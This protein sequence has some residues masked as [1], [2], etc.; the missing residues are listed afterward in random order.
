MY[1]LGLCLEG[2]KNQTRLDF[3]AL[4]M[5]QFYK[6]LSQL[7]SPMAP[8][9]VLNLYWEFCRMTRIW[10]WMKRLKWSGYART[11]KK[12]KEVKAR[13][14]AIFCLACLQ[15]GINIPENWREDNAWH[16]MYINIILPSLISFWRWVYKHIF[17]T[18]GNFKADH[19]QQKNEVD[20]IWLSEGSGMI[21]RR[22]EY[23]S[24]LAT[25]IERLTVSARLGIWHLAS[26]IWHSI[27]FFQ[28][29]VPCENTFRAIQMP[30][31]HQNF[32]T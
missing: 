15:P 23:F 12:V 18:D 32:A 26:G 20:D 4:S 6:L 9:K 31:K 13:E 17:V 30:C 2:S 27:N 1:S 16:V 3:Q 21:P 19:V 11:S 14:L 5:Y 28:L 24:F 22:E 29:K 8:A 7:T 25:T 10:H